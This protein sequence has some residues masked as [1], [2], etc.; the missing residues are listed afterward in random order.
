MIIC[1]EGQQ[2]QGKTS[3][4]IMLAFLMRQVFKLPI[5]TNAQIQGCRTIRTVQEYKNLHD[6]IFLLDEAY[7]NFDSRNFKRNVDITHDIMQQR[8]RKNIN[9]YTSQM[10]EMVDNRLRE[11]THYLIRCRQFSDTQNWLIFDYLELFY[12]KQVIPVEKT[13]KLSKFKELGVYEA[14][15]TYASIFS[16]V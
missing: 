12:R 11:Q 3:S 5:V 2:G 7:L 13:F 1:F 10:I 14:F 8:K 16:L 4:A 9:I 6:C 15:D